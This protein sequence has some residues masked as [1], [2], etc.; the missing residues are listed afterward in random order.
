MDKKLVLDLLEVL[1]RHGVIGGTTY[2]N[3]KIRQEYM[4]MRKAGMKGKDARESLADTYFIDVKTVE[5]ALY[6][7]ARKK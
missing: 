3:E 4:S 2:R 7:K 6:P 5:K 1:T